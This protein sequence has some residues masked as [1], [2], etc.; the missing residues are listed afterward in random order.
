MYNVLSLSLSSNYYRFWLLDRF[1]FLQYRLTYVTFSYV[2]QHWTKSLDVLSLS[3][4]LGRG[5][6]QRPSPFQEVLEASWISYEQ[7]PAMNSQESDPGGSCGALLGWWGRRRAAG[8]RCQWSPVARS[9]SGPDAS[10][11]KRWPQRKP[12]CLLDRVNGV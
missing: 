9:T 4:I 10:T 6:S 7:T 2:C 11:T 1:P 12:Q 3:F 8:D 5:A